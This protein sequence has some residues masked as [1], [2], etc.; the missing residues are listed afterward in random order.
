MTVNSY[1]ILTGVGTLYLAPA[2][3]TAPAVD[4]TPAGNWASMGLTDGG[5]KITQEQKIEKI[6]V[7]QETGAVKAVRSEEGMKIETKLAIATL[8]N[9]ADVL[10]LT[11]TD[12][13]P[14]AATIGTRSVPNYRGK[15]VDEY[16]VLFRGNSPY[17]ESFPA[18]YYV[19][20]VYFDGALEAEFKKDGN[21]LIPVVFEALVDLSAVTDADK[22]GKLT[23]QDATAT[24]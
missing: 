7:D 14:G 9:L 20:R 23:A 12:T 8:E 17:G 4:A 10:G 19:P 22:F 24:G 3:E 1:E 18:Q 6:Y 13:A 16:A 15:A 11:V 21:V 2:G 5:V